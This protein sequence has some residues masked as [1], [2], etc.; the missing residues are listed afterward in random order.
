MTYVFY[1]YHHNNVL[2][3]IRNYLNKIRISDPNQLFLKTLLSTF[4]NILVY[5][6]VKF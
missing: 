1:L 2:I 4:I 5:F 3:L 6:S